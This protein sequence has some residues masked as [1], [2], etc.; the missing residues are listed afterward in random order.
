MRARVMGACSIL[1]V[2]VC[3]LS[4]AR[5][6][7]NSDPLNRSPWN[8]AKANP[9]KSRMILENAKAHEALQAET[10]ATA[11]AHRL[12]NTK[13]VERA[14]GAPTEPDQTWP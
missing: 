2:A 3:G 13:A 1:A 4:V 7:A 10:V 9:E 8:V 6:T 11:A 14:W 12:D 5:A